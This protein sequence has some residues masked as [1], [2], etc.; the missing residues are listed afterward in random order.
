MIIKHFCNATFQGAYS[1]EDF[2]KEGKII[3]FGSLF[4]IDGIQYRVTNIII[5]NQSEI[6][7]E[8][9]KLK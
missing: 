3:S 8:S 1:F 7:V 5:R 6:V 2:F 4:S 9:L